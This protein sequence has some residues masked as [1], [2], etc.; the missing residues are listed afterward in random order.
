MI[1]ARLQ[2]LSREAS[3]IVRFGKKDDENAK[4]RYNR[5]T[6]ELTSIKKD[7]DS[8]FKIIFGRGRERK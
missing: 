3:D 7:P 6:R 5:V 1:R 8:F 2:E 4:R